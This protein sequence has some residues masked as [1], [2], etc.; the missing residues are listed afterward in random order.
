MTQVS[1]TSF[2]S[3]VA[4]RED[5]TTARQYALIL[6]LLR[7]VPTVALSRTDI[8]NMTGIRLS[9]VCGRIAELRDDGLVIE[10]GTRKCPH[11]G[12]TV[13]IVQAAP[14][15]LSTSDAAIH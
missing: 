3:Y 6:A 10:P 1:T 7:T 13:K 2:L 14:D 11:T 8:A 9:S 4:V 15:L 5:G 12:K